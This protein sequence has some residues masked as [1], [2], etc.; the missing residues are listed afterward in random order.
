MT[1]EAEAVHGQHEIA[2][3]EFD[4]H[5]YDEGYFIGG[6]KSGY[7]DYEN[8]K[9]IVEKQYEIIDEVMRDRVSAKTNVDIGCAYGFSCNHLRSLDWQ[10]DGFDISDFAIAKAQ[11]KFGHGFTVGNALELETWLL[12]PQVELV[13]GVEFFE[14]I[15]SHDVETVIAGAASIANWGLFLVNGRVYPDEAPDKIDGDHGHLNF[16]NMSWWVTQFAKFGQVDWNAMFEFNKLADQ[17][18]DVFWTNRC[19]IVR[20][21]K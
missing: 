19:V 15:P 6:T 20:F 4:A 14:H 13:T 16:H 1:D 3:R 9:G 11:E 17:V 21:D 2:G 7:D 5:V 8:C 10:S 12:Q 18:E